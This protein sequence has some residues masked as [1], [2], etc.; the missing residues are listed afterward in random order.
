MIPFIW[1]SRRGKTR[2]WWQKAKRWL[3]LGGDEKVA[4]ENFLRYQKY[5]VLNWDAGYMGSCICQHPSNCIPLV[6]VFHCVQV[7]SQFFK[8]RGRTKEKNRSQDLKEILHGISQANHAKSSICPS[9]LPA[10]GSDA[11]SRKCCCCLSKT[12]TERSLPGNIWKMLKCSLRGGPQITVKVVSLS[13]DAIWLVSSI[14]PA[15]SFGTTLHLFS[16]S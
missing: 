8:K 6:C 10:T 15:H 7:I 16:S 5:S 1:A 13:T 14:L 9:V 4:Q 11:L 12:Q 2:L 3:P